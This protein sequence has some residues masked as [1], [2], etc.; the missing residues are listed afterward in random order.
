MAAIHA[1]GAGQVHRLVLWFRHP[2]W[3]PEMAG[4]LTTLDSQLWWRPGWGHVPEVPLLTALVGGRAAAHLAT[5]AAMAVS[6]GLEHL[7]TMLGTGVQHALPG[8]A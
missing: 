1:L 7:V 3:P 6:T 8:A 2:V 4:V 5:H